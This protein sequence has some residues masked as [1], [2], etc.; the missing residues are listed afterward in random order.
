MDMNLKRFSA[1]SPPTMASSIAAFDACLDCT[2]S[3]MW[4]V[5]SS[6]SDE[7]GSKAQKIYGAVIRF[8]V[9]VPSREKSSPDGSDSKVS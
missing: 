1:S 9:P 4:W 8:Y 2:S 3:F 5:M 6:N 7:Y